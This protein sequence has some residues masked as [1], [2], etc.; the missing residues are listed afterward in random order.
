[1]LFTTMPHS[2]GR[3]PISARHSSTRS[4]ERV[5][6]SLP[7]LK[8]VRLHFRPTQRQSFEF[9]WIHGLVGADEHQSAVHVHRD[10]FARSMLRWPCSTLLPVHS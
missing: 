6:A 9:R 2:S 7:A 4:L 1:M 8:F 10:H 5:F 3:L